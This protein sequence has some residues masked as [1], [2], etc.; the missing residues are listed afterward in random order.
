MDHG[1]HG[2]VRS[3]VGDYDDRP[4]GEGARCHLEDLRQDQLE[5][6]EQVRRSS[7]EYQP[8]Y[9]ILDRTDRVVLGERKDD[10]G[11][12][13]VADHGHA[14][15]VR[16]DRELPHQVADEVEES[17]PVVLRDARTVVEQEGQIERNVAR[18]GLS[19]GFLRNNQKDQST[20]E[21]ERR[22]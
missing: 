8:S 5:G 16:P 12:R 19:C 18:G 7:V 20:E 21:E 2:I 3:S 17:G 9:G 10:V 14:D 6:G 22:D 4:R 13:S 15:A 11:Y 1:I